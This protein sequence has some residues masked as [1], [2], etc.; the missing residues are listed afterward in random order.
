[1]ATWNTDKPA[2]ANQVSADI[3]D[4]EENLQEL[5]DV[6]E[7]ITNGT[8][9]TTTAADFK[10]K[11]LVPQN[12]WIPAGSMIELTTNGALFSTNEYATNDIMLDYFAFD[13]TAEEYV[14]FNIAMPEGWDRG[15]IKAKFYWAPGDSACTAGDTVEWELAVGALSDDDAIDAALGT[16]QVISDTILVG[17]DGDL[18]ITSATPAITVGGTPA[19]EDLTHFKASRNVAGTDDMTEDAWLFGVMLQVVIDQDVAGW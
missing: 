8:L 19:L 6:I 10:T 9:G 1:M 11:T 15:T 3:P 13:G 5:H 18:H 14:A 7:A 17:K 12:I 4:I 16:S 2:L